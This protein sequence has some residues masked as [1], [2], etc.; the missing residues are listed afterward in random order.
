V[1]DAWNDAVDILSAGAGLVAVALSTYDPNRFISADHYGGVLVGLVVILTGSR[2]VR[3]A[4]LELADTMP[5]A[6]LTAEILTVATA[7]A[8]GTRTLATDLAAVGNTKRQPLAN[9]R[10]HVCL[11]AVLGSTRAALRAGR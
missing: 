1:A 9:S 2:V 5:P 7:C 11:S 4:S 6:E 10:L 3:D 8:G